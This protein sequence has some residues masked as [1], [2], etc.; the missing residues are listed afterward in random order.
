MAAYAA[1]MEK[2]MAALDAFVE[3]ISHGLRDPLQTA[4]GDEGG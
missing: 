2:Q 3:K 4:S 1:A